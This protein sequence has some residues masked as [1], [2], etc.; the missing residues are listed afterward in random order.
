MLLNDL[1]RFHIAR[2]QRRE[3]KRHQTQAQELKSVHCRLIVAREPLIHFG[4]ELSLPLR[5]G[6]VPVQLAVPQWPP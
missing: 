3:E 6:H 2:I 4:L 1:H 5:R